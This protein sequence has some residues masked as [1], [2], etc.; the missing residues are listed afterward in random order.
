M[1]MPYHLTCWR[2]NSL[3]Q[4]PT[5]GIL[6]ETMGSRVSTAFSEV[7]VQHSRHQPDKPTINTHTLAE[8]VCAY[9]HPASSRKAHPIQ[10]FL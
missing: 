5:L 6:T 3:L 8:A 4:I 7:H 9:Q 1:L 10:L 2:E